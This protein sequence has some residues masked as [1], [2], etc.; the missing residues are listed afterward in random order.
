MYGRISDSVMRIY[1]PRVT[2]ALCRSPSQSAIGQW[3]SGF[4]TV[5]SGSDPVD[6][7][8]RPRVYL[9]LDVWKDF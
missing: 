6:H 5:R 7:C 1:P 9:V 4:H 3:G 2:L 8:F